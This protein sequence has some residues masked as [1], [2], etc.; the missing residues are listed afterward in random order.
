MKE[1]FEKVEKHLYRR[2]YQTA[3]GERSTL[4]YARFKDCK[5]K[6]RTFPLGS[7]L[8]TARE[9]LT[10]YEARNIR[11]EDFDAERAPKTTALT[12]AEWAAIY[13]KE[14]IDPQSGL[15]V[16]IGKNV[17]LKSLNRCLVGSSWQPLRAA[18]SWSIGRSAGKIRSSGMERLL[19]AASCHSQPST[20]SSPSSAFCLI[21][22]RMT[23][24]SN[25]LPRSTTL[26][27]EHQ[28]R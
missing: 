4:Y 3:G 7:V 6:A 17:L 15:L 9:E 8:R 28:A 18:K 21:W 19:P 20:A 13:F 2:Q 1:T 25:A 5:G 27:E 26:R 23:V 11:R 22:P 14:K 12:F 24:L 10:V 16:S